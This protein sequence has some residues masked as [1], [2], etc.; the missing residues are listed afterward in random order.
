MTLARSFLVLAV[1]FSVAI[2]CIGLA[3]EPPTAAQLAADE[4]PYHELIV[5][6]RRP[7]GSAS[8][9]STVH[10]RLYGGV[11]LPASGEGFEV[12]EECVGRGTQW[13]TPEL[14][15]LLIH[16]GR[17]I[18]A[19]GPGMPMMVCNMSQ[20]GGGNIAWSRSHNSGRDADIAF[21]V[22]SKGEPWK[23]PGLVPFNRD[24]ISFWDAGITFDVPRNWQ[25]MRALLTHPSVHVQWIFVYDPLRVMM[26]DHARKIGE[27]P[28]LVQRAEEVIAQPSDAQRHHDHF[29]VR[30][31][32]NPTERAEGCLDR[33]PYW[34]WF[35]QDRR[36]LTARSSALA[37]GLRDKNPETRLA[38]LDTIERTA[39]WDAIPG[40]AE[41]AIFDPRHEVRLRAQGIVAEW[42]EGDAS[43]AWALEQFVRSAKV[44]VV[45]DDPAYSTDAVP[46]APGTPVRFF[47]GE[48]RTHK[49]VHLRRAWRLI[50]KT[51]SPGMQG[52]LARALASRRMLSASDED[53][54]ATSSEALAAAQ[55]ASHVM[56]LRLVPALLVAMQSPQPKVRVAANRALRRITAY[57]LGVSW[58]DAIGPEAR[59]K[60]LERWRQWWEENKDKPRED[61]LWRGFRRVG[62]RV[63]SWKDPE[64]PK[65][66]VPLTER[67]D[68]IGYNADRVLCELTGAWSPRES[69]AANRHKRWLKWAQGKK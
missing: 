67:P 47:I 52:F 37:L 24:G 32:C 9:G 58:G 57:R 11:Q 21:F 54:K 43:L 60:N 31:F 29:H 48:G 19:A 44:G 56:D 23:P 49:P 46:A 13:G 68:E 6:K 22:R 34:P 26:L 12:F 18:H 51:A 63:V 27:S 14:V 16:A 39:A 28:D 5:R 66:L 3:Q 55:A 59:A 61:L 41:L 17:A 1:A 36:P 33:D 64:L 62:L 2:P 45:V 10:G 30:V 65:R 7:A 40:I 53:P 8:V 50:R 15:E 25:L 69:S 38:V 20:K 35:T 42:R 4:P